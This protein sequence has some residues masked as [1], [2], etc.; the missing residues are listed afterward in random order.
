MRKWRE[1]GGC[2][3]ATILQDCGTSTPHLMNES[4]EVS[5]GEHL[6]LSALEKACHPP[7]VEIWNELRG[8]LLISAWRENLQRPL[9]GTPADRH[10]VYRPYSV[11]PV[12]TPFTG[13]RMRR[14]EREILKTSSKHS[15]ASLFRKRVVFSAASGPS[16]AR[17]VSVFEGVD[18][19]CSTW[20]II[21]QSTLNC[22]ADC[23]RKLLCY[24]RRRTAL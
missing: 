10:A 6:P 21:Y 2:R 11:R 3:D 23:L 24:S 13:H 1:N 17:S 4:L 16:S 12:S 15:W 22:T 14:R 7:S 20:R 9:G 5:H 18:V 19:W 8:S